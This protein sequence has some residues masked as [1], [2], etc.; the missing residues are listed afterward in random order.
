MD[1]VHPQV[2]FWSVSLREEDVLLTKLGEIEGLA[3]CG[4]SFPFGGIPKRG[5]SFRVGKTEWK[6]ADSPRRKKRR[7]PQNVVG[8]DTLHGCGQLGI[9]GHC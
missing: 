9:W 5:A 8:S 6:K 3:C 4:H 2:S 7:S 1:F